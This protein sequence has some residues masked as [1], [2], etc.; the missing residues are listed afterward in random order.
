MQEQGFT[1]PEIRARARWKHANVTM[2][3]LYARVS[4]KAQRTAS[5]AMQVAAASSAAGF[6]QGEQGD[7]V[8]DGF[9]RKPGKARGFGARQVQKVVVELPVSQHRQPVV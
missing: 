4:A 7:R 8:A 1:I 9:R 6:G 3:R 2:M 5:V